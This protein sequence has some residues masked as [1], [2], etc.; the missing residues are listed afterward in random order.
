MI[1]DILIPVAVL[2]VMGLLFGAG[3]A[4]ASKVFAVEVDPKVPLVREAL[5][6]ANCGA[7]GYPGCD[8]FATAVVSGEGPLNGCPVGGSETAEKLAEIM[9]MSAESGERKVAVVMCKGTTEKAKNNANYYGL[10]DCREA[11][12]A[13]GGVKACKYGCMGFGTCE[14]VCPFD[15]IHIGEN[16][17]PIV[18]KEACTSCGKCIEAC[19]KNIITLLPV[20]QEVY[21]ACS[22]HDKLK[23]VKD[24]CEVGCIACGKCVK[25]CPFDAITIENNLAVVDPEKCKQCN[26][27]V[28]ECPTNAITE[29]IRKKKAKVVTE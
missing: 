19:P 21:V 26:L 22:S 7:C 16:G 3:L 9:G 2:G 14:T 25:K 18:D 8:G 5:P 10:N 11:M 1:Y 20:S 4:Y 17:L 28:K 23:A 13:S 29:K 27:C 15:A 24:V 12:I 6:G